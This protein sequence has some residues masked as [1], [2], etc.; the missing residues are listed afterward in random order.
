MITITKPLTLAVVPGLICWGQFKGY[1]FRK[2]SNY[3]GPL[4]D[5]SL[6]SERVFKVFV[7]VSFPARVMRVQ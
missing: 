2:D 4:G 7:I 5:P 1:N 3:K 6:V